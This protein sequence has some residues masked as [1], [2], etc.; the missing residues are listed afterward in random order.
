M[1]W[2]IEEHEFTIWCELETNDI[3]V[4]L[5][6]NERVFAYRCGISRNGL[7]GRSHLGYANSLEAAQSIALALLDTTL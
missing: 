7:A 2:V 4:W 6:W 1:N 5:E 3:F